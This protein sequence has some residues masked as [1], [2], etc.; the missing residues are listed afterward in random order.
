MQKF[1]DSYFV[2]TRKQNFILIQENCQTEVSIYT[3]TFPCVSRILPFIKVRRTF[4]SWNN[5]GHLYPF[6]S[7]YLPKRLTREQPYGKEIPVPPTSPMGPASFD[8]RPSYQR[9]SGLNIHHVPTPQVRQEYRL[10]RPR[11]TI[12]WN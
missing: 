11:Q 4:I 12:C 6:A 8:S 9:A 7:S 10:Q 5:T 1:M 2:P 3:W